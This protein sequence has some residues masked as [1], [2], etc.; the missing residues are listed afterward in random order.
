MILR[1]AGSLLLLAAVAMSPW[2]LVAATAGTAND[3]AHARAQLV[4]AWIVAGT[5]WIGQLWLVAAVAPVRRGEPLAACARALARALV[6]WLIAVLAIALGFAALV[7]PGFVLLVLLAPTGASQR[8]GDPLPAP[9]VDAAA[10]ARRDARRLALVVAGTLV[11]DL[12]LAAVALVVLAPALPKNAPVT[13]L[14]ETRIVVV[15]VALA[16]SALAP[17]PAWLVAR[18]VGA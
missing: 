15:A 9:L 6:P 2:L 11:V 1:R 10:L 8:L 5:A 4:S 18:A 16:A 7:V 3:L 17:L 13:A 12:A 14:H